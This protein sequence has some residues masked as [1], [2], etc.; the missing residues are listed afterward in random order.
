[1][2][3]AERVLGASALS[4]QS[5]RVYYRAVFSLRMV[6]VFCSGRLNRAAARTGKMTRNKISIVSLIL[7][8]AITLFVLF[9]PGMSILISHG[10]P[11]T[12]FIPIVIVALRM[13]APRSLKFIAAVLMLLWVFVASFSVGLFYVPV[14]VLMFIAARRSPPPQ[15]PSPAPMSDDEFWSQRL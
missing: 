10:I 3:I 6:V 5:G 13:V 7:T 15:D 8:V 12:L 4:C 11:A 2:A 14:V 9:G 1:L